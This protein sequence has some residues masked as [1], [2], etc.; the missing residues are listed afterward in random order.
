[1]NLKERIEDEMVVKTESILD[2]YFD[3][4]KEL[5]RI[6]DNG[7]VEIAPAYKDSSW[8]EQLVIYTIGHYYAFEADRVEKESLPYDYFYSRFDRDNSTIRRYVNELQKDDLVKKDEESGEWV[9]VPQ[10]LSNSL[11]RIEGVDV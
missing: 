11:S 1:M 8:K 2:E 10:S 6:F 9:L 5:F 7:T 3:T 4:A